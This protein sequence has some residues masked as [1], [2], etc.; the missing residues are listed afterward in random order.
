M[1]KKEKISAIVIARNEEGMIE[2][3]LKTLGW[4]DEIIVVD[5]ESEDKTVEIAKRFTDK[6]FV[7]K[8]QDFASQ[9]NFGLKK[10]KGE[11]VLYVDAD[12]RVTPSLRDEIKYQILNIKNINAYAIPR[13]NFWLGKEFKYGGGWTDYVIRLFKKE[14]LVGWEGIIHEQPKFEGELGKLKS[15][16]IHLTHRSISQMLLKTLDWSKKEAELRFEAGHP[17]VTWW[18]FPRVTLTQFWK[19]FVIQQVW[20]EGTEGWIEGI[21]QV[22]SIFITYVRLWERQKKKLKNSKTPMIKAN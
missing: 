3:C 15:P 17:K 1:A 4:V 2:N 22:F 16:L 6:V 12:E 8:K 21:F 19:S 5:D 13:K 10:A 20:R 7:H 18:R 11:W 9:R 14:K